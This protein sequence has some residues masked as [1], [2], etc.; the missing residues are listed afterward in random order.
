MPGANPRLACVEALTRWENGQEFADTILHRA[1]GAVRFSTLDRALFTETFYGVIRNKRLLDFVIARLREGDID[2]ATRQVLRL[3]IYQLLRMRIPRHA[4]VN[5][6]V[7]LAGR[8]RTLVNAVLRRCIRDDAALRELIETAPTGVRFSHP[9]LLV[10]RWSAHFGEEKS[11][12]LCEWNNQPAEVFVRANT[13]KVT[14]GELLRTHDAVPLESHLLMLRVKKLPLPWIVHGLCY[15]Q[16]PS[17]LAACEL[18][19]PEPGERVLDACAAPGGKT[20]Y[21]AALMRNQGSIIACDASEKRLVRLR[22][23]LARLGVCNT[24][25]R[26]IDW[27][28]EN[29][30]AVFEEEKFDRIL[31]DAPCSNT[32]VIRRRVDVRWRLT[33]DEFPRMQETQLALLRTV[34]RLLKSGGVLVYSTCSIEPEENENLVRRA[35]AEV[36]G[37]RFVESR[38]TLP[39]RDHVDGAFAARFERIS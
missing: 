16:D 22:Q 6:T 3:G 11:R 34:A 4:V 9:E 7:E 28:A 18:L 31:L 14:R 29:A 19:A 30:T 39:F 23:N 13:L 12:A 38:Q 33:H 25:P 21:L 20:S 17:T 1:L 26:R 27:L 36:P 35:E 37:L 32:G 5:E 2:S 8:A 24:Q 10:E 15:V